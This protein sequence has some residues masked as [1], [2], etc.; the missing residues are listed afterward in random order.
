MAA[1]YS[2]NIEQTVASNTPILFTESPVPCSKGLVFHQDGSG[3]FRLSSVGA[4]IPS[5]ICRCTGVMPMAQYLVEFHGNAA[6]STGG[7]VEEIQLA[8]V[9]DGEVDPSS[10]MRI[11][12][13][14]VEEYQNVGTSIVV[15][16]P[17][18]CRCSSVSVRNI[19]TQDVDVQN[20][21]I[22]IDRIAKR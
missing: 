20:A 22:L 15:S 1:E 18:I 13:A 16:V 17:A 14:A 10:I 19:S 8:I 9:V 6:I 4:S 21:N 12:P 2:A 5:N 11:T 3:I 7:T